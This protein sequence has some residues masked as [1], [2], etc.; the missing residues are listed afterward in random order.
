MRGNHFA[1]K[2]V[3]VTALTLLWL[4]FPVRIKEMFTIIERFVCS[5]LVIQYFMYSDV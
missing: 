5:V 4:M 3:S 2:P 1:F